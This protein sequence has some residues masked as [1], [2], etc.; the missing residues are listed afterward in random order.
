MPS[1][2]HA[3]MLAVLRTGHEARRERARG[4]RRAD[5]RWTGRRT[6][7]TSRWSP[8]I[9]ICLIYHSHENSL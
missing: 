8:R 2:S 5:T 3:D 6:Q 7:L 9:S 1:G 4:G